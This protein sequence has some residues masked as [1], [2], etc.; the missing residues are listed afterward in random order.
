M[1]ISAAQASRFYQEI[2][3]YQ[4]VWGIRDLGGFPAPV[5]GDGERSMPFW[6]LRSRAQKVISSVSVYRDFEVEAIPLAVWRT[7]WID[8]LDRDGILVGLNWSGVRATG[9]DMHPLEVR[10][11]LDARE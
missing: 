10:A 3:L 1:S 6:S 2:I 5:N 7:R 8:G 11:G 9:Y 4:Q